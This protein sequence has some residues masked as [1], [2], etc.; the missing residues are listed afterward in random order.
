MKFDLTQFD[1]YGL[2]H[3]IVN[4]V[5]YIKPQY[6]KNG[7]PS[8]QWSN[9]KTKRGTRILE[10]VTAGDL[11]LLYEDERPLPANVLREIIFDGSQDGD[12]LRQLI[13]PLAQAN[14]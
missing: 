8:R 3:K 7:K 11:S 14:E 2:D 4:G 10:Y 9:V 13:Q 12:E 6:N 5:L 1:V